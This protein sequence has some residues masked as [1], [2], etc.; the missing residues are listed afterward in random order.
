MARPQSKELRNAVELVVKGRS[1][2]AFNPAGIVR[3][4][5][6]NLNTENVRRL[7]T[8]TAVMNITDEETFGSNE[9]GSAQMTASAILTNQLPQGLMHLEKGVGG[10]VR[11]ELDLTSQ[12]LT[13]GDILVIGR[14]K[15]FEG[16]SEQTSDL[17][18]EREFNVLVPRDQFAS[19]Q[20]TIR[21]DDEGGDHAEISLN[22]AN[23]AI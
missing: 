5:P 3:V 14:A 17:D 2:R 8:A 4:A 22:M 15:L 11:V 10:E 20:V 18:G 16:T 12:V 9:M 1:A 21:N 7:I 13:N 23:S 6:L 19:T